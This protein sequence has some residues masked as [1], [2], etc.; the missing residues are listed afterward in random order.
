[1]KINTN[2]TLVSSEKSGSDSQ[3]K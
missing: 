1:M 3:N 2:D